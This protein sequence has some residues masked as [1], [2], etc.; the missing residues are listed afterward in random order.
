MNAALSLLTVDIA[1]VVCS[2]LLAARML[3]SCPRNRSAQLIA[4]IA[5]CNICYVV[6]GRFDYGYWIPPPYRIEIG[7]AYGALNFARNLTPGLFML[8]CHRLYSPQRHWPRWALGVFALQVLLEEPAR[9]L[10]SP[11]WRLAYWVT[12]FAPT[13]L[14]LSFAVLAIYW[15]AAHWRGDLVEKRRRTRALTVLIVG[16]NV[17]ASSLLLRVVIPY[18]S[19]HNYQ[20]HALLACAN[21]AIF[22][23]LLI[24]VAQVDIREYLEPQGIAALPLKAVVPAESAEMLVSL[25]SLLED[26]RIY[27]EALSLRDLADR[28]GLPEYRLRKLIHEQ[29]GFTNYNAFI[30]SYR[31]REACTLLLDP[32]KRRMPIL[33]IALS[34]GYQSINTFNRAFRDTQG[35]TPSEFR[36]KSRA[37]SG[38][39][40]GEISPQTE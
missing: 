29:L 21:L 40:G 13:L 7:A 34:V 19:P 32:A 4:A 15:A 24:R 6:L 12:E 35:L 20:A 1:T 10:I 14:Q 22:I 5:A 31:I 2:A 39:T 38:S 28:A 9:F 26:E 33:T 8:L 36:A 18:D 27:R 30:N 3:L 25:R 11:D 23:F 16:L 37:P 17:M